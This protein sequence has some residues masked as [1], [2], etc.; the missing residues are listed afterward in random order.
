MKKRWVISMVLVVSLFI[1]TGIV[2]GGLVDYFLKIDGIP[3]ESQDAKHKDEI[4]LLSWSWGESQAG[5]TAARGGLGAGRV[6]FE[7]FVFTTNM[8][9]A[10]LPLFKACA[11]G[12]RIKNAVF[13]ARKA[14]KAQQDFYK[15]TF[16]DILVTNYQT[17]GSSQ[18]NTLPIDSFSFNYS[19]VELEYKMQNLDGSLGGPIKAGYDLKA[20]KGI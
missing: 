17:S 8:S 9:K 3:G 1:M 16:S 11:N 6:Q 4:Q 12:N 13:T 2:F 14:G 19:K 5:A 18:S 10:S 7:N 15:I 20:M